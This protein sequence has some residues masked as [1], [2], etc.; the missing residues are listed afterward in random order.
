[1]FY[2]PHYAENFEFICSKFSLMMITQ[3]TSEWNH[4]RSFLCSCSSAEA[5][6][7]CDASDFIRVFSFTSKCLFP[8]KLKISSSIFSNTEV[9]QSDQINIDFLLN[10]GIKGLTNEA[11]FAT[12][13]INWLVETKNERKPFKFWGIGIDFN[14]EVL[15][16]KGITHVF[17][18]TKLS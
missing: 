7:L 8:V 12:N 6:P 4:L 9:C 11:M 16:A 18:V 13:F 14:A 2:R 3:S 17:N 10:S 1:M 15:S 5:R